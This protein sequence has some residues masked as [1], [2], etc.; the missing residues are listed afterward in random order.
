MRNLPQWSGYP[1]NIF[2]RCLTPEQWAAHR[3]ARVR[4]R[5]GS[6]TSMATATSGSVPWGL[7]SSRTPLKPPNGLGVAYPGTFSEEGLK[8]DASLFVRRMDTDAGFVPAG[9]VHAGMLLCCVWCSVVCGVLWCVVVV[10]CVVCVVVVW[11]VM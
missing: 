7:S 10:W 6:I 3:A 9:C 11:R 5:T 1:W 4:Q 2:V 8:S